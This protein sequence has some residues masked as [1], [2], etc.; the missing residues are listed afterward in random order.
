M[1][2]VGHLRHLFT[3]TFTVTKFRL[4]EFIFRDEFSEP[5]R[6]WSGVRNKVLN[7]SFTMSIYQ[8]CHD[9]IFYN[10]MHHWRHI[11]Q[12]I[13]PNKNIFRAAAFSTVTFLAWL[14][15]YLSVLNVY[16]KNNGNNC[17]SWEVHLIFSEIFLSKTEFKTTCFIFE[18]FLF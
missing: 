10:N 5:R 15:A 11:S 12:L 1:H 17:W 2:E 8:G 7:A 14:L 3:F 9:S 16:F 18:I 4:I 13:Y 6:I